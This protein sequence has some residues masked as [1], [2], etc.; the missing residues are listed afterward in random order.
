MRLKRMDGAY[1]QV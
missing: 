1:P